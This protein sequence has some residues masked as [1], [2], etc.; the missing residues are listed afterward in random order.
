MTAAAAPR[1]LRVPLTRRAGALLALAAAAVSGLSVFVNEYAVKQAPNSATYTTA[2]NL[3]AAMLL[4]AVAAR[5]MRGGLFR[6]VRA[7]SRR[8]V[9]A[10]LLVGVLGGGVA[11]ALFFE[12]LRHTTATDAAFIQKSLIVWVAI[13]AVP[14]LGERLGLGH[15]AA[16]ALLLLGQVFLV[17]GTGAL[18][19]AGGGEPM[20]L[21]ATLIWSGEIIVAR[22]LL[23]SLPSHLLAAARMLIGCA[24][25]LLYLLASGQVHGLFALGAGGWIW[26]LVTGGLLTLYVTAWLAALARAAAIDVTAILVAG[27]FIT[28]LFDAAAG[29]SSLAR[30][31][32][33]LT[34][35]A[36]GTAT[37]LALTLSVRPRPAIA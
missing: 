23:R 28:A 18:G 21:L 34:L 10:L 30:H 20:I 4:A 13:A 24:L 11:F 7:L 5:L 3:V 27:A 16:I 32:A 19:H 37:M 6:S 17:G 14:V 1:W 22:I 31:A 8:Q 29:H 12:G 25:L 33:G 9:L 35:I 26:A 36:A 15:V 2:K